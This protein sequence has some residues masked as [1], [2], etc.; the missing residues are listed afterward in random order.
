VIDRH[1]L[2]PAQLE[3]LDSEL[4]ALARA[5]GRLRLELG[6]LLEGMAERALH[7]SLG[8]S[9]IAAYALE[10]C[11]AGPGGWKGQG[12]SRAG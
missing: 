1:K 9:S 10:R 4:F 3:L 7:F 5:D 6:Q 11:H 8:F 2:A 12:V